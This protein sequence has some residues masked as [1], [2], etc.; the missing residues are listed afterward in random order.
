MK[1]F[2]LYS[3]MMIVSFFTMPVYAG[4]SAKSATNRQQKF[5]CPMRRLYSS[6]LASLV[7]SGCVGATT[8]SLLRYAEKKLNIESSS[9][10][11]LLLLSSWMLESEF[12]NDVI[13]AIQQDLDEYGIKYKKGLM[14]KGAWIAS[15]LAYLQV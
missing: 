2:F 11:L 7:V 3:M 1:K 14:F 12:R 9:V 15:W 13:A 10:A 6:Y 8:G 4:F 5:S